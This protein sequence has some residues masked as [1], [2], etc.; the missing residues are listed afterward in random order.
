VPASEVDSYLAVASDQAEAKGD[1]I[2]HLLFSEGLAA[3]VP[4]STFETS[5]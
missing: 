2:G 1:C 3:L 5:R 4:L